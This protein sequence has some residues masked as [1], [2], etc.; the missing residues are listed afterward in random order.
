MSN[1]VP[2][3]SAIAKRDSINAAK[4]AYAGKAFD[5]PVI[6]TFTHYRHRKCDTDAPV[7]KWLIDCIVSSGILKD[8]STD[9]IKEIRHRFVKVKKKDD[10][11]T[12][13]EIEECDS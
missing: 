6:L 3:K 10:E 5:T 7:P 1:R 12:I 8:D 9:E 13:V 2:S 4:A 11:K